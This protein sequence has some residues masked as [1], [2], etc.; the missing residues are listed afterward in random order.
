VLLCWLIGSAACNPDDPRTVWEPPPPPPPPPPPVS[1]GPALIKVTPAF[2]TLQAIGD[3]VNVD[4]VVLDNLSQP[5]DT[6]SVTWT[7][8]DEAL[9]T[10]DTA[11]TIKALAPGLARVRVTLD[12]LR[13]TAWVWVRPNP[14]VVAAITPAPLRPLIGPLVTRQPDVPP[15][16][17]EYDTH[18]QETERARFDEFLACEQTCFMEANHYGGLR[19]RLM[20]A[21]RNGEPIGPAAVDEMEHAYARG[22]RIVQRYLHWSAQ[23]GYSAK[24]E[25]NTALADVETLWLLDGDSMA[26]NHIWASAA[27]YSQRDGYLDFTGTTSPR[28]PTVA[29]MAHMA[30]HRLGVPFARPT[31]ISAVGFDGIM[32]S[33]KATG[34]RQIVW[35]KNGVLAD[36]SIPSGAHNGN[37]AYL[38]NAWMAT[39]LLRWCAN[40]EWNQDAF[41]L[42]RR[43]MDHLVDVLDNGPPGLETLPYTSNQTAP[44]YDLAAFYVWPAL[45]LWQETG[46]EKYYDFALRNLSATRRAYL[47]NMKQWNQVYGMLAQGAEALLS[48]AWWR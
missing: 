23:N 32:G 36:G 17:H 8:V 44:A 39:E 19:S 11:G 34:E 42:A 13:A 27:R 2:S 31:H 12:T 6:V 9:A 1:T 48:G 22:R 5:V 45:A 35:M 28:Q 25:H 24:P 41:D 21:I 40:I 29:L 15:P 4:A 16:V 37:E 47:G 26:Y 3:S 20:W 33:W 10:V 14:D 46:D 18:Y 7:V 38:F 43:V 30:A